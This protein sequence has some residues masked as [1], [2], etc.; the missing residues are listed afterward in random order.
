MC[1]CV[2]VC[3][4]EFTCLEIR[5]GIKIFLFNIFIYID[6]YSHIQ[7]HK[8]T[9]IFHIRI[10]DDRSRERPEGSL[11]IATIVRRRGDATPFPGLLH[12]TLDTYLILL[13]VKQGGI[14][15]HF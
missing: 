4:C 10:V 15:Y 1:V 14:E 11:S 13:S 2:C 8:N 7:S 5:K 9:H 12:F 6:T 3:V